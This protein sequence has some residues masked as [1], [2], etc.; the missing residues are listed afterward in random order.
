LL[1]N[2]RPRVQLEKER[3]REASW[4]E[5][6]LT[7]VGIERDK[8]WCVRLSILEHCAEPVLCG[9]VASHSGFGSRPLACALYP[10]NPLASLP[11][12]IPTTHS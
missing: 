10:Q 7:R 4:Y 9:A 3:K 12:L 6:E 11:R 2:I 1:P 8:I 5:K